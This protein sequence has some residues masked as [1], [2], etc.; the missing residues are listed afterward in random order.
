MK[1]R[2]TAVQDYRRF[3]LFSVDDVMN[4][5]PAKA[6]ALED[7]PHDEASEYLLVRLP[8]NSVLPELIIAVESAVATLAGIKARATV[9]EEPAINLS[10]EREKETF[11]DRNYRRLEALR[12]KVF[13]EGQWLTA[14]ELSALR[15]D[16]AA[17][18]NPAAQ[19]NRWKKAGKIFAV[20]EAGRDW[21]PSWALDEGG[22]PLPVMKSILALFGESKSP[23]AIAFWFH[24]PNSW[25]GG[26]RPM[27][28]LA[29]RPT[30][31]VK[32]AQAEAEGPING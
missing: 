26:A 19:A 18:S 28:L 31:V 21:F 23:W 16:A 8:R 5:A 14:K 24:A 3:T 13:N 17:K 29:R 2:T 7:I 9:S 10:N 11:A 27:D 4:I 22:Q 20:T 32:A 25:L 1:T 30:D 15:G 6:V 12:R